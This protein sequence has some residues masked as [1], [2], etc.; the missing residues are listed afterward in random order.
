MNMK[1]IIAALAVAATS[2]ASAAVFNWSVAGKDGSTWPFPG[3]SYTDSTTDASVTI[4][5]DKSGKAHIY[6]YVNSTGGLIRKDLNQASGDFSSANW[7]W[8]DG[9]LQAKGDKDDST[10]ENIMYI[11]FAFHGNRM[12]TKKIDCEELKEALENGTYTTDFTYKPKN[13][14]LSYTYTL[15]ISSVPEPTSG[16][17]LL[18]GAGMLALR[19]KAVRA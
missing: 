14:E 4:P 13:S 19:R 6:A 3:C 9:V 7:R 16:L 2:V 8:N 15:T 18:L 11:A 1:T 12:Q 10:W 17:L 5:E